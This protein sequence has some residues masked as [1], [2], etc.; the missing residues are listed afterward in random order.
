MNKYLKPG[1][2]TGS[3]GWGF[4]GSKGTRYR[5]SERQDYKSARF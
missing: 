2:L 4:P 3:D 5:R 1:F